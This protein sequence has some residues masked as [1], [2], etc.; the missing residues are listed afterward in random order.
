MPAVGGRSRSRFVTLLGRPRFDPGNVLHEVAGRVERGPV[1]GTPGCEHDDGVIALLAGS[2]LAWAVPPPGGE[3]R[4]GWIQA[5]WVVDW[6]LTDGDLVVDYQ[7]PPVHVHREEPA[8]VELRHSGPVR[9][10]VSADPAELTA[11]AAHA[12]EV[13]PP[14]GAA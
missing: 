12:R 2:Q 6:S 1:G 3:D 5:A 10:R 8:R 9:L 7:P 13:L 11:F 14:S 4:A